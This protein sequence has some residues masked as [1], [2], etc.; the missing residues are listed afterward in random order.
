MK[1]ADYLAKHKISQATL[2]AHLHVSQGRVWQWLNGEQVTPKYCPEIEVWSKREVTCEELNSTVKWRYVRDSAQA[3]AECEPVG[4]PAARDKSTDD[5]QLPT[6]GTSE[7]GT[8]EFRAE[9]VT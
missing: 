4:D 7:R 2:A 8:K 3:I 1:L 9:T 6:G 5:A